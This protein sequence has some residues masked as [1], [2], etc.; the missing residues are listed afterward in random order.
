MQWALLP[1]LWQTWTK[2]WSQSRLQLTCGPSVRR[3]Q[4]WTWLM[5]WVSTI[6]NHLTAWHIRTNDIL[7]FVTVVVYVLS[8]RLRC[9]FCCVPEHSNFKP[10]FA[11]MSCYICPA[12]GHNRKDSPYVKHYPMATYCSLE[13][14]FSY[15]H[16][17]CTLC[18]DAEL[19]G[20]L[21][22]H[23]ICM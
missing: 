7:V 18:S 8:H 9:T 5:K 23:C 10:G 14:N 20:T 15:L 16:I 6:W 11:W 21:V 12:V 2:S 17:L 22:L 4:R 1:K 13:E 3:P 19:S